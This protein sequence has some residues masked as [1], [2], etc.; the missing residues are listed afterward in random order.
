MQNIGIVKQ[1]ISQDR[2]I[3][4]QIYAEAE[5]FT[6]NFNVLNLLYKIFHLCWLPLVFPYIAPRFLHFS[7][8]ALFFHSLFISCYLVV[9]LFMR[10][11]LYFSSLCKRITWHM[12]FISFSAIALASLGMWM[13]NVYANGKKSSEPIMGTATTTTEATTTTTATA[14]AT[15]A[16]V[17]NVEIRTLQ[18]QSFAKHS[19]ASFY[20]PIHIFLSNTDTHMPDSVCFYAIQSSNIHSQWI[21]TN[22][23]S[24]KCYLHF[25][26][27][28][29]RFCRLF[30]CRKL[31]VFFLFSKLLSYSQCF[32]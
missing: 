22:F 15:A 8:F 16:A 4:G 29:N 31:Q 13:E 26:G 25:S 23:A 10:L 7:L 20:S 6:E 18:H 2:Q 12:A 30:T 32:E 14:A 24:S 21:K 19:F 9:C 28:L 1:R 27:V 11:P 5:V 3:D 17:T